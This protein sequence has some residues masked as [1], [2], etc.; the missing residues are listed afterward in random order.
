MVKLTHGGQGLAGGWGTR[1]QHTSCG[2]A[3]SRLGVALN[4][5]NILISSRGC[6]AA[7]YDIHSEGVPRGK[8]AALKGKH[9]GLVNCNF[10]FFRAQSDGLYL[11][12]YVRD[13]SPGRS[14]RELEVGPMLELRVEVDWERGRRTTKSGK[15]SSSDLAILRELCHCAVCRL[16]LWSATGQRTW[17]GVARLLLL[18]ICTLPWALGIQTREASCPPWGERIDNLSPLLSCV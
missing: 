10:G 7:G 9:N 5:S 16:C 17:H 6:S 15:S 2:S 14:R 18:M 4:H 1:A 3:L 12:A 11:Y 8:H 13:S